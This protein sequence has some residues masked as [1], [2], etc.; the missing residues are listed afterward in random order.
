MKSGGGGRFEERA[1]KQEGQGP[2]PAGPWDPLW[3]TNGSPSPPPPAPAAPGCSRTHSAVTLGDWSDP[4]DPDAEMQTVYRQLLLG[5]D[6]L[7][8]PPSLPY[9][10][11][12]PGSPRLC[13]LPGLHSRAGPWASSFHGPGQMQTLHTESQS[14]RL[15]LSLGYDPFPFPGMQGLTCLDSVLAPAFEGDLQPS[16]S[17]SSSRKRSE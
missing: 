11:H 4:L 16:S 17:V 7:R 13:T 9:T 5:R 6:Q 12:L 10:V 1:G 3:P 14:P 15:A 2:V 8:W